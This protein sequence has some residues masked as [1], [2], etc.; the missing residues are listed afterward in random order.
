MQGEE[1]GA[2]DLVQRLEVKDVLWVKAAL[3]LGWEFPTPL[4]S[5]S[6]GVYPVPK[7]LLGRLRTVASLM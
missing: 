4:L 5:C 6:P 1:R 2:R 7:V 3:Y